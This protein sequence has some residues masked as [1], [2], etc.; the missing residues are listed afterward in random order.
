MQ[1]TPTI[2]KLPEPSDCGPCKLI[3]FYQLNKRQFCAVV[4]QRNEINILEMEESGPDVI[5]TIRPA[6]SGC[7][8]SGRKVMKCYLPN[9]SDENIDGS[10]PRPSGSI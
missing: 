3:T 10:K 1:E 5:H 8:L 9:Y 2:Q 4:T 7:K 6:E